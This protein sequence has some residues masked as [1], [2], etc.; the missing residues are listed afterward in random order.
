MSI[1]Y[2][3]RRALEAARI[4][5]DE[6]KA[7]AMFGDGDSVVGWVCALIAVVALLEWFAR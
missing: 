7:E 3:W 2:A 1:G 4:L 5:R 6:R